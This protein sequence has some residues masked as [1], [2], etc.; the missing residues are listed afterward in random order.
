MFE[1]MPYGFRRVAAYNPFRE[2]EEMSR[3]LW[4]DM[5]ANPFRTDI[6]EKDGVYTLETELPGFKK[7]DI[8]IDIEKD[9]LTISA[10]RKE[11]EEDEGRSFIRRERFYDR[12]LHVEFVNLLLDNGG[13]GLFGRSLFILRRIFRRLDEFVHGKRRRVHC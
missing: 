10:E 3:S 7:D 12:F 5:N 11:E 2:M 6:S 13:L 8:S 1:I 9:S 4:N